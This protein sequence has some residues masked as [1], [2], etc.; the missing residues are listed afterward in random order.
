MSTIIHDS[1]FGLAVGDALGVPVEFKYRGELA[2]DPVTGIR[3]YGT[4]NQPPGTWS[5]DSSLT[6]CLADSLCNGYNLA[7]IATKFVAWRKAEIWTP[8]GEVFDIGM[9]THRSIGILEEI[10]RR[11]DH[12]ALQLL[13]LEGDEYTNGNG[14][15]MRILPLYFVI[16]DKPLTEQ[17][18]QVWAVSALTHPHIRSALACF[19][20]LRIYHYLVNELQPVAAVE[21]A[22]NDFRKLLELRDIVPEERAEFARVLDARFHRLPAEEIASDGY[23]INSLE[24]SVWCFLRSRTYEETI[25]TAINL[26]EDTDTTAAI[27][28]GLA[29]AYYGLAS[30]PLPWREALVKKDEIW[31]LCD[32]FARQMQL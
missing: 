10:L 28:G 13:Y 8:H 20:Y 14:S 5:D 30:I 27:V 1:L 23:V 32:A 29:G 3:G 2:Q 22:R 11:G 9:T 4:Y 15:L 31:A 24:A 6:F 12:Q 7:D 16:K 18:D 17:L 19:L 21:S 26:G 25:L